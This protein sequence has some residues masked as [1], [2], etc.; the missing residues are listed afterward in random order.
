MGVCL[1]L[2]CGGLVG[3]G[4]V[5]KASMAARSLARVKTKVPDV[6]IGLPA[7]VKPAAGAV[8]ATDV[9]VPEPPEILS[10]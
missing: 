7:I 2:V 9:T 8:A 5:D 3:V 1:Y 4:V 10:T 6:V